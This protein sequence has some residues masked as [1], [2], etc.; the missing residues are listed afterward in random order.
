MIEKGNIVRLEIRGENIYGNVVW[1][2][3]ETA[4]V[5][6]YNREIGN[7]ETKP[8][9]LTELVK[10]GSHQKIIKNGQK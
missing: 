8:I 10:I 5:D 3:G 1:I 2:E 4:H 9:L 7:Y 6:Y